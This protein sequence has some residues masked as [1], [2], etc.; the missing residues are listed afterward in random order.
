[1]ERST[2]LNGKTPLFRLGHGF[3]SYVTNYQRVNHWNFKHKTE[4]C[5]KHGWP[6]TSWTSKEHLQET[7]GRTLNKDFPGIV[8]WNQLWD[9]DYVFCPSMFSCFLFVLS[10]SA[11][12]ICPHLGEWCCEPPTKL[13]SGNLTVSC[14]KWP[15]KKR[16]LPIRNKVISI[17]KRNKLP[18]GIPVG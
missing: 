4:V 14:W 18:T 11:G 1:M 12:L 15:Q 7:I 8:H 6:T 2:M 16:F 13:P 5:N 3:N 9:Y 10:I 17:A